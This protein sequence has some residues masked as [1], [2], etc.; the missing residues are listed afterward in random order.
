MDKGCYKISF[1]KQ[2]YPTTGVLD[3]LRW[4][5]VLRAFLPLARYFFL[6]FNSLYNWLGFSIPKLSRSKMLINAIEY[7]FV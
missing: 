5:I 3:V 7:R 1:N 6:S 4:I 2:K